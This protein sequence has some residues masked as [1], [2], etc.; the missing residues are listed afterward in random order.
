VGPTAPAFQA[1]VVFVIR[2]RPCWKAHGSEFYRQPWLLKQHVCLLRAM[3]TAPNFFTAHAFT[4]SS[5]RGTMS[6][7]CGCC[8]AWVTPWLSLVVRCLSSQSRG[9]AWCLLVRLTA[10]PLQGS[11][12]RLLRCV[13]AHHWACEREMVWLGFQSTA[14]LPPSPRGRIAV[15][16][17]FALCSLTCSVY[18]LRA[19]CGLAPSAGGQLQGG[20]RWLCAVLSCC[21]CLGRR[22]PCA[23]QVERVSAGTMGMCRCRRLVEWGLI[24]GVLGLQLQLAL[25]GW[26]GRT[27]QGEGVSW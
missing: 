16:R 2:M 27:L 10:W 12:A 22:V 20:S 3:R 17:R 14:W 5:T 19:V 18:G 26:P 23:C 13:Q 7:V 11:S 9:V 25:P 1:W 6:V 21:G 8:A 4:N 15:V 24:T